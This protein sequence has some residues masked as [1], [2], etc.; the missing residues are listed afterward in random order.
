MISI[1]CA[2][3]GATIYYTKD[4]TTPTTSS[5]EYTG[6][7][8]HTEDS[9]T[10]KAIAVKD[11]WKNSTVAS[12]ALVPTAFEEVGVDAGAAIYYNLQG[13]KEANPENGIFIK[14]QGAKATKVVL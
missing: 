3:E 8:K 5:T 9:L 14:K 7:F 10:V 2:T 6:A 4:G 13:V 11:G 12:E 1:T